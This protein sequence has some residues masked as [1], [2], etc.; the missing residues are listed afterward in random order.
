V[1]KN[2]EPPFHGFLAPFFPEDMREEL[3]CVTKVGAIPQT[4][5]EIKDSFRQVHQNVLEDALKMTEYFLQD[6][7]SALMGITYKVGDEY[8]THFW[9]KSKVINLGSYD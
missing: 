5:K 8:K 4:Y 7:M 9:M 2:P 6:P 3:G 1:Q